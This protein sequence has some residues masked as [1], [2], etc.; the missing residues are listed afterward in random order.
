MFV[1]DRHAAFLR[2]WLYGVAIRSVRTRLGVQP[3]WFLARMRLFRAILGQNLSERV[4][5]SSLSPAIHRPL[6]RSPRRYQKNGHDRG[7]RFFNTEGPVVPQRHYC[8]P[9]LDRLDL[10]C[11]LGL[12]EDQQY[13]I[14]RGSRQA[15]K[16]SL[17]QALANLLNSGKHGTYRC[18]YLDVTCGH[19][20]REDVGR[21][22][23]AIFDVLA[24]RAFQAF[25]DASVE[26][27]GDQILAKGRPDMALYL[28]LTRWA[29]SDP[30]PLVLLIDEI[31]A[32]VGDTLLSVLRQLRTGYPE[33]PARF[34]QSIV[35]CG[36]RDLQEYRIYSRSLGHEIV[37]GSAFN[38][39]AGSLRLGDFSCSELNALL[40]QHTQ[41]TG[42]RFQSD[43]IEQIWTQTRGQPWL[44]NALCARSCFHDPVGLDRGNTISRDI[45]AKAQEQLILERVTH[46]GHLG[47]ILREDRVRK[48]IEPILTCADHV[49][50]PSHDYEYLR[51]LGLIAAEGP[52]RIANP[53]YR[54]VVPRELTYVKQQTLPLRTAWFVDGDQRLQVGKLLA[55]F[56]EYFRRHSEHGLDPD[57]KEASSQL[58]LHAFLQRVVDGG[59][60]VEREYAV[61]RGRT[62]LLVT[63]PQGQSVQRIVIECKLLRGNLENA[64]DR[65]LVQTASYMDRCSADEGHLVIFDRSAKPWE[66]KVFRRSEEFEG[67]PVEAWGM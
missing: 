25:G 7:V 11:I 23:G 63:W 61:G 9:P 24:E 15:G 34:P 28:L 35:L 20:A 14:L 51:D 52:L 21:G 37:G 49:D 38:I 65:G 33:R 45:V 16:T 56:Q 3:R 39:S 40:R 18:L 13:F 64:I 53:I 8:I 66:E 12:I 22:M 27:L 67:T 10:E 4:A 2:A 6:A 41:E 5:H 26:H 47:S 17:L 29:A 30:R 19:A 1:G 36:V 62:D 54:E 57:Y 48:A 46:F 43:A 60:L 31:D 50:I 55:A 32:L 58:L 59:G 44:V 42:Q